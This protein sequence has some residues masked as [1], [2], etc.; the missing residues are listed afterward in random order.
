MTSEKLNTPLCYLVLSGSIVYAV[1]LYFF[2]GIGYY[3]DIYCT[4]IHILHLSQ[5]LLSCALFEFV[6]VNKF[7]ETCMIT[8]IL[9]ASTKRPI[10]VRCSR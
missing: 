3:W 9:L 8:S 10:L 5:S 2:Y 7:E 1:L 6:N 4:C